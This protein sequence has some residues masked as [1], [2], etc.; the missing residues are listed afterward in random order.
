MPPTERAIPRSLL[1][2]SALSLVFI[3][4]AAAL[5][6]ASLMGR[7]FLPEPTAIAL[8]PS[9]TN[10][11]R[12][13]STNVPV[14]PPPA[15]ATDTPTATATP[16][17]TST[18]TPTATPTE[19]PTE[20]AL[21]TATPTRL[22]QA[23]APQGSSAERCTSVVGDSVAQGDAVFEVSGIGFVSL[24]FAP[25]GAYLAAQFRAR[26][27]V[28]MRVFNRTAA[29]TAISAPNHPSYFNTGAFA[30][31][32]ADSCAYTVI[33]PFIND[34]TGGEAGSYVA[35]L[36]N[37]ASQVA[38]RNPN[39]KILVANFYYGMPA[40]FALN[41]AGGF[42]NDRVAAFNAAIAAACSSGS[43]ALP[44]VRCVDIS[45]ALGTGMAHLVG[46][47]TRAEVEAALVAPPSAEHGG[48][49]DAFWSSNPDGVLVGDGVHLSSYGKSALATILAR[50]MP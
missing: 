43:L 36:G 46:N 27:D 7:L 48:M 15:T 16:T 39:G 49:L 1:I 20:T 19:T 3:T 25:V 32:L 44:Q 45:A 22:P 18:P 34:L 31:L 13:T 47:M 14:L 42:S 50:Q 8:A 41:F 29:A 26:G 9:A 40:P 5:V 30:Q 35:A 23:A 12:P 2:L 17:D 6:L 37:L 21:P 33:V 38:G 10:T 24:R 4:S 28:G 11:L